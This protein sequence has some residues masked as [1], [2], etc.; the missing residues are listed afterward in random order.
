MVNVGIKEGL[1]E[2]G[3]VTGLVR[4]ANRI[5]VEIRTHHFPFDFFPDTIR[6]EEETVTVTKRW[7]IFSAEV[8]SV[9]MVNIANVLMN[10]TPFFAQLTIV[11]KTFEENTIAIPDLWIKDAIYVRRI[12]EGMRTMI[13]NQVDTSIYSRVELI[14]KLEELSRQDKHVE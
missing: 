10:T 1:Q 12:I 14:E 4:Q 5:L 2:K 11:S 3:V 8:Y 6:V 9:N 13:S 7:F